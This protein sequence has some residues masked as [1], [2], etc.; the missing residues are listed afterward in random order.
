VP[1][2]GD[3]TGTLNADGSITA[4][5]TQTAFILSTTIHFQGRL[6]A[7]PTSAPGGTAQARVTGRNSLRL[8]WNLPNNALVVNIAIRGQ[9]CSASFASNL[10]PG[11]SQHTLFDGS[12]YHYCGRPRT[13]SSSCQV[14]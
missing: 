4:D 10:K 12:N 11:K 3:G 2:S 6:G 9:S 1:I 7:P 5:V 13:F 8:I 14:R